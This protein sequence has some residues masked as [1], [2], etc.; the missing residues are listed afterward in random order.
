MET[1]DNLSRATVHDIWGDQQSDKHQTSHVEAAG[2]EPISV[3]T[4]DV[5]AG[6]HY[7]KANTDGESRILRLCWVR[8]P[9]CRNPSCAFFFREMHF[10][11]TVNHRYKSPLDK[12]TPATR[13]N[14]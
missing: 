8:I 4:V 10:I 13:I 1:V 6:E 14:R 12:N 2:Q 11:F 9:S 7:D 5:K 3:Q